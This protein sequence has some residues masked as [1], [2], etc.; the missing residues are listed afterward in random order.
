MDIREKLK[1][2]GSYFK[3]KLLSGEFVFLSCDKY[4]ASIRIDGEFDFEIWIA[5][6][7]EQFLKFYRPDDQ[8]L[9]NA[10]FFLESTEERLKAWSWLKPRV[11]K[12]RK[13][14]ILKIEQARI[15]ELE[16]LIEKSN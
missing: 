16:S 5:N 4:A 15:I 12:F 13:D 2:I 9:F 11:E 10:G 3:A 8:Q 6:D 14:E 7:P 1:E